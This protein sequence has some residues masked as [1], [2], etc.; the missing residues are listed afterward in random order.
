MLREFNKE[1]KTRISENSL[2]SLSKS[3]LIY[4]IEGT[5]HTILL[6][7]P[8][9]TFWEKYEKELLTLRDNDLNIPL[10]KLHTTGKQLI[11][12][13]NDIINYLKKICNE[14]TKEYGI[15]LDAEIKSPFLILYC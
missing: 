4:I 9:K 1:V 8:E 6:G 3:L 12:I 14:Y 11:K 7:G 2:P 15:S 10:K 13:D 5:N